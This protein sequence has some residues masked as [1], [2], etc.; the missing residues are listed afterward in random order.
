MYA[1][2]LHTLLP[3][4]LNSYNYQKKKKSKEKKKIVK[5]ENPKSLFY[6]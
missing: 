3:I 2:T 5:I 1:P 6:A 4:Y